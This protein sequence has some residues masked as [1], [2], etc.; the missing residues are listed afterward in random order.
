VLEPPDF[1]RLLL[2]LRGCGGQVL[3]RVG[4]RT[5]LAAAAGAQLRGTGP[6]LDFIISIVITPTSVQ[7]REGAVPVI[8]QAMLD[9]SNALDAL[10]Q[11]ARAQLQVVDHLLDVAR[12]LSGK[13]HIKQEPLEPGPIIAAAVKAL[14]PTAE[15]KSMH[16]GSTATTG[17]PARRAVAPRA[18]DLRP[19]R[20][21][22]LEPRDRQAA[23]HQREDGRDAPREHQPQARCP[24][25]RRAHSLR[26]AAPPRP[27]VK[28][29]RERYW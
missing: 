28:L 27:R 17:Y 8:E 26:G 4:G 5:R 29:F 2:G 20:A 11:S 14:E 23:L 6:G 21:E 3:R 10:D 12:G 25:D 18:R 7:D 13:L 24:L 9:H 16:G 19:A 1:P 22:P 15:A